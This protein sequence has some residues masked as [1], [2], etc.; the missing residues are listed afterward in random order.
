LARAYSKNPHWVR[1]AEAEYK[2]VIEAD[3]S[4]LKAHFSLGVIYRKEKL[5]TRAMERFRRVLALQPDHG[6][7]IAELKAL[8]PAAPPGGALFRLLRH[9]ALL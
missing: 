4:N 9:A 3:P 5:M 2:R 7:A 1:E 6:P 8:Q